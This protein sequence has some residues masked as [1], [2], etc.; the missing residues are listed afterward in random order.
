MQKVGD[1]D[2]R[3]RRERDRREDVRIHLRSKEQATRLRMQKA[4]DEDERSCW[5]R[6]RKKAQATREESE[7]G[8]SAKRG[9]LLMGRG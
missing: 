1:E 4:G 2:V 6:D 9:C 7:T 3:Q 8:D 5:E